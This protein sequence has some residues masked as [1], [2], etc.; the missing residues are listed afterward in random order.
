RGLQAVVQEFQGWKNEQS[1]VVSGVEGEGAVTD[2][3]E[4]GELGEETSTRRSGGNSEGAV[5]DQGEE[6]ESDEEIAFMRRIQREVLRFCID[7]LNHPLQDN[8][9]KSVIISGL[10]V[11]GIRDDD[12]WLNAE[13]YTSK[14]SAVAKLARMMVVHEGYE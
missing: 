14:Y 3:G 11:L 8:E 1:L 13:D 6:G 5:T 4:E 10:A 2:Q 7:L 12:G 9:Y